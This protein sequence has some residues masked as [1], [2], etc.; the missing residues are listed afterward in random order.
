MPFY[1]TEL[2]YYFEIVWT[3]AGIGLPHSKQRVVELDVISPQEGHILCDRNAAIRGLA[4][5]THRS[6]RIVTS[7]ISSPTTARVTLTKATVLGECCTK[8]NLGRRVTR[9]KSKVWEN[10]RWTGLDQKT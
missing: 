1:V 6:R 3:T 10:F 5:R 9:G 8:A 4:L 2:I 7:R